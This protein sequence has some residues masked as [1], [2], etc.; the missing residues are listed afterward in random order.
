MRA[1]RDEPRV[2]LGHQTPLDEAHEGLVERLHPVEAALA[3]DVADLDR[4][5]RVDD[6]VVDAAGRDEH[7]DRGEASLAVGPRHEAPLRSG[8]GLELGRGPLAPPG[9]ACRSGRSAMG[10]D[11][12]GGGENDERPLPGWQGAFECENPAASYSPRGSTPKYH[13]R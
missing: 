3:D 9:R 5:L 8:R 2:L 12:T 4:R 6:P 11:V 10:V 7:L 1:R 13:R